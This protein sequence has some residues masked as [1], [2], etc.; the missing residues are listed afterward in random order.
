MVKRFRLSSFY[1]IYIA[2]LALISA[3]VFFMWQFTREPK[4]I[5]SN[6]KIEQ[7]DTL[8]ISLKNIWRTPNEA[9][10]DKTP[11]L[12]FR[13]GFGKYL[14]VVGIHA[15][16]KPRKIYFNAKLA[17][18]EELARELEILPRNFLVTKF[19]VPEPLAKKGIGASDIIKSVESG[20]QATI[21]S[22]FKI[23]ARKRFFAEPFA[24]P[25]P[26][27]ID[28]GG[29]GNLRQTLGGSVG[30]RHLGTDLRAKTGDSVY[31]INAGF[32]R[33]AGKLKNF[34]NTVIID[35]GFGIFSGYL[36]LSEIKT[37]LNAKI[38]RGELIGLIGSTGEYSLAPHLHLTI[39]IG[40]ASVDPKR[41]L[42]TLN[43]FL[44]SPK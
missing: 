41:F 16:S 39:K 24:W 4:I 15:N 8:V 35:H 42:D 27:W 28:V 25:L 31:S 14:A 7:G 37:S 40:G 5:F 26:E 12:F 3:P 10:L 21:N 13:W 17:S 36:H 19:I 1:L 34:G 32:V 38:K 6:I 44:E 2:A 11:V 9:Y 20:D 23:S 29:F 33:F 18:G 22:V 30:A 43:R